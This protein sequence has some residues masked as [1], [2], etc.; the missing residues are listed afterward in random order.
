M[1]L[2]LHVKFK[3]L[4]YNS[5]LDIKNKTFSSVTYVF[6]STC[7]YEIALNLG[8]ASK[9]LRPKMSML[10]TANI[11]WRLVILCFTFSII[12]TLQKSFLKN[13]RF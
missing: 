9:D 8:L 7:G 1:I 4:H 3:F 10:M 5:W 12:L 2:E 13:K 6:W 11:N